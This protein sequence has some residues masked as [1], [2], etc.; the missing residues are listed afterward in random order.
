M[1]SGASP[2]SSVYTSM[3]SLYC[4]LCSTDS[5]CVVQVQAIRNEG[6]DN[7]LAQIAVEESP[8]FANVSDMVAG[9]LRARLRGKPWSCVCQRLHPSPKLT[10][11]H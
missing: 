4:I 2:F 1:Y 3:S 6:M 9:R 10:Y 7:F 5:Q 8:D 11:R